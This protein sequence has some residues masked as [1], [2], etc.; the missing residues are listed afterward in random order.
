MF[1]QKERDY[2]IWGIT[3]ERDVEILKSPRNI[4]EETK[5]DL[6]KMFIACGV[7][8]RRLDEDPNLKLK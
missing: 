5:K 6:R 3:P 4:P 2:E 8:T 1:D 7:P